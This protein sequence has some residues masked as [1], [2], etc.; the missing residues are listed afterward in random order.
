MTRIDGRDIAG[1][2]L[3][4][5]KRRPAPRKFL[6]AFM[7]GDDSASMSFL[8]QKEEVAAELRVDFRLYRFP[9]SVARDELRRAIGA[10]ARGGTCG[11]AIVQLPLPPHVNRR[12][13]LNAIPELKDVD[14]LGERAREAFA[15]EMDGRASGCLLPPAVGALL[16]VLA[17]AGREL[18]AE[19]RVVVLGRGFLVG[20]PVAK[21]FTNRTMLSVIDKGDDLAPVGAAD[22]IVCGAGVPG[23]LTP[24]MLK[25]GAGVVDFGYGARADGTISGDFDDS[26]LKGGA[27]RAGDG[28]LSG[29]YTPTPGGTG[30]ILVAKLMENFFKLAG[31]AET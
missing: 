9:E 10:I 14:V 22:L 6:A 4:E 28:G 21:Y 8:K 27:E 17:A 15:A 7:V 16:E 1:R 18:T 31:D 3:K 25:E 29:F 11:G 26:T 24:E 30:P 2:V 5:L 13:I 19:A 20:E 12:H 23:L